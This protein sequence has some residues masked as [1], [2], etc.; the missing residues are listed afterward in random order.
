M[1][2]GRLSDP[3][4]TSSFCAKS[5]CDVNNARPPKAQAPPG[6]NQVGTN[7]SPE[8]DQKAFQNISLL[9][10]FPNVRKARTGR[11]GSGLPLQET[12]LMLL[13][14][15]QVH[16]TPSVSRGNGMSCLFRSLMLRVFPM[17]TIIGCICKCFVTPQGRFFRKPGD[18][19][20]F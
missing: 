17:F 6:W 14:S 12:R 9:I 8:F 19:F 3:A 10:V 11:I 5:S 7:N 1:V 15:R 16:V 2:T 4:T 20:Y 13:S 18:K